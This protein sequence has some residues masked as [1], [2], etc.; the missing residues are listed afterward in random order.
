MAQAFSLVHFWV[1]RSASL[2][3]HVNDVNNDEDSA[4]DDDED[5]DEEDDDILFYHCAYAC[6]QNTRG[7]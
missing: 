7:T 4:D 2:N 5:E 6:K 3:N 1:L